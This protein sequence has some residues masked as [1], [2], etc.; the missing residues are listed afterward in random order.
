[1]NLYLNTNV[2]GRPFDDLSHKKILEEA[3]ASMRVFMLVSAGL[4]RVIGSE[5]VLAEIGKISGF[6]KR[7]AIEELVVG[8]AGSQVRITEDIVKFSD[9]LYRNTGLSD[10]A[11]CLHLASGYSASCDYFL[12]CDEGILKRS[13]ILEK[14]FQKEGRKV[15]KI[16][17]PKQFLKEEKIT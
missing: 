17:N 16:R 12:T 15:M 3:I 8:L 14:F 10:Y 5:I 9:A 2:Y 13:K 7:E 4:A 6:S 1:M 11:D